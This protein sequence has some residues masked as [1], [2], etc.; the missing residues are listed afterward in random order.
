[1]KLEKRHLY[2]KKKRPLHL[3]ITCD[4]WQNNGMWK[5]LNITLEAMMY[6]LK[7]RQIQ[8]KDIERYISV[9]PATLNSTLY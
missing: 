1:M 2:S 5:S 7:P 9:F 6:K 4:T 3:F 8:Q